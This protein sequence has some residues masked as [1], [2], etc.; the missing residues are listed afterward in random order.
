M[1]NAA[2]T[3]A[4]ASRAIRAEAEAGYVRLYRVRSYFAAGLSD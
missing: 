2:A 4:R 1:N 3:A